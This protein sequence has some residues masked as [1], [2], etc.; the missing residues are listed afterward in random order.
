MLKEEGQRGQMRDAASM[1]R[2]QT[3]LE[4]NER[5]LKKYRD[6]ISELRRVI[7]IGRAQVGLGDA[8][9]QNDLQARSDFRA[10]LEREVELASQGQAGNDA[11]RFAAAAQPLLIQGRQME[12]RLNDA[13]AKLEREVASRT[14]D[15]RD[16]IETER[17]NLI[18]YQSQLDSLDVEAK[19]LVGH[20]AE[21]NFGI[22]REKL[23]GIVLRADVGIT[24]QAWEVREEENSRVSNLLSEKARQEQLLDEE[25]KEV[26]DDAAEPGAQKKQQP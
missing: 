9:F 1:Q 3:E 23:K 18:K 17:Q 13:F 16:K 7:E 6:Q 4:A 26:R 12:E 22:V 11:Q 15:L 8:R 2:L 10:A 14:Q 5:D 25:L 21:R 20:V 24:E 19:D